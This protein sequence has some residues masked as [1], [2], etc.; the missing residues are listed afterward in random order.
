MDGRDAV[1]DSLPYIDKEYDEPETRQNVLQMIQDEMGA[2]PP[3]ELPRDS[4]SLFKGKEILR[5]EY[6]RVRSGKPLPVFDVSRYKLEPPSEDDAQ[7]V[8]EWKRACDNAAAQLEHQ[9]IRLVN[10]ELLQQFGANAWKFSNYQKEKLLES[11]ERATENHKDEGVR[12]NKARKYE[13]TEAGV[14]LRGLED[15]WS[16]GV[17]QCIEIQMA[18]GQL[19]SEIEGLEQSQNQQEISS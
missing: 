10:L 5:K 7:S 9:D 19:M 16:E 12:I 2:M 14:K 6:E 18:S 8:D 4:M 1:V 13:Q 11:I 17:R 3:P 15:R